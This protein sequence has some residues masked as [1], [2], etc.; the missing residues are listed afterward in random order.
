M[1]LTHLYVI[2]VQLQDYV[3][4]EIKRKGNIQFR[5]EKAELRENEVESGSMD[6]SFAQEL[7]NMLTS[8]ASPELETTDTSQCHNQNL[9]VLMAEEWMEP[10]FQVPIEIPKFD[11]V[12]TE[13][14]NWLVPMQ[15]PMFDTIIIEDEPNIQEPVQ[16]PMVETTL[17]TYN[18]EP[19]E[20]DNTLTVSNKTLYDDCGTSPSWLASIGQEMAREQPVPSSFEGENDFFF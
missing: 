11:G 4:S 15:V 7:D 2:C 3:I 18:E 9:Q 17:Y 10:N 8:A 6:D 14:Q 13:D 16:E 1:R 19:N 5:D 12:L 20:P